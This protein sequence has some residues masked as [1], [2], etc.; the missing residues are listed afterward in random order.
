MLRLRN[1]FLAG[2]I[3]SAPLAITAYL[4]WSFVGWVDS[5][6]KPLIPGRY[7]P[8]N[9][10]PFA[11]PGLGL[12]FAL[13]LITLVG[14]LAANIIGRSIVNVGE[15]IVG[16]MPLVRS[17]YHGLKQILET[18]LSH[19]KDTFRKVALIEYPRKGLWSI[20]YVSTDKYNE[21]TAKLNRNGKEHV[22]VFLPSTPNPTTGYL[23]Y[24]PRED[25]LE[26]DMSLEEGAKLIISAGIV[27]PEYEEKTEE[28]ARLAA[29]AL[30]ARS[31]ETDRVVTPE[32]I[33][34]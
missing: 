1:Y 24:V 14:F 25:M 15:S 6:M 33:E 9:Y 5:W 2:F 18:V 32:E 30:S 4:A 23:L 12:L 21:A 17:I 20:A 31:Q 16:R 34:K 8:D 27:A 13:L 3:V 7:N 26:L 11:I 29:A 28:L 22:A 10:L 19:K